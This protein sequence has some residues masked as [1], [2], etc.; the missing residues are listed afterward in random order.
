[1]TMAEELMQAGREAGREEGR[2]SALLE[3]L[4][5]KF[6]ELPSE[7]RRLLEGARDEQLTHY[8]RRV[9]SAPSLDAVFAEPR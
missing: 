5:L 1:M 9:L 7:V 2:L 4:T 3:L 6:G 8:L